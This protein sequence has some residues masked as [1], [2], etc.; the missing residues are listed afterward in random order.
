MTLR[1]AALLFF[2]AAAL[3]GERLPTSGDGH[4]MNAGEGAVP[5]PMSAPAAAAAALS[6]THAA[7]AAAGAPLAP[8]AAAL[9]PTA[10]PAA[11]KAAAPAPSF[12]VALPS[13][14]E[15]LKG[16]FVF[17]TKAAE[18][19]KP[20]LRLAWEASEAGTYVV[21]GYRVLRRLQGAGFEVRLGA[22]SPLPDNAAEDSVEIGKVY[23][24]AVVAVDAKGNS[25][26][27]S[28]TFSSDLLHLDAGLLAPRS[29]RSLTATS[30]RNS[31]KLSWAA[32]DPWLS[33]ISGYKVFRHG[34]DAPLTLTAATSYEDLSPPALTDFTYHVL[35]VDSLGRESAPSLT[36]SARATGT[37][38]PSAPVNLTATVKPEKASLAWEKSD[39]G[40]AP[41][42]AYLLKRVIEPGPGELKEETKLFAPLDLSRTSYSDTVD[43]DHFY[44]YELLAADLE[45]N[46]S[47]PSSLR[48]WVPGKPFN[49]T[50]LLLMPTAYT[51]LPDR[52]T[53]GNV[54]VLFDL[55]IGELYETYTNPKTNITKTGLFQPLQ[56]SGQLGV[57]SLDLKESFL[58]ETFLTP[59]MAVGF[60]GAALVPFGGLSSQQVAVTSQG[61]GFQ[62]LGNVYAVVSKRLA[63]RTAVHFGGMYGKLSDS[64]VSVAPQ[65]W[66]LTLRHLTPGGNYPDLFNRFLDPKLGAS[67]QGAPHMLFGGL[68]FPLSVP[69]GFATW[70]TGLKAELMAPIYPEMPEY[71]SQEERGQAWQ[72]L[73]LIWNFHIDNLPLFGF[74][75][76]LFQFKGGIEWIAFYHIPDL[77]WSF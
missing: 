64:L 15:A 42:T 10:V 59:A 4:P 16:E 29:P 30:A 62:T 12:P 8:Q 41:V 63:N 65:D 44:R 5:R 52:D 56:S 74:E 75:F 25:S 55:Y 76:S 26:A 71:Y 3:H 20:M 73:P 18:A 13:A 17:L 53:G 49:K 6:V 72:M 57:V 48:L 69:F 2:A 43:G 32:P 14:P 38:A 24:Y 31:A 36:V 23:D 77:T 35:S 22:D 11:P 1:A 9:S 39:P 70:K 28:G 45:G 50:A 54:N 47:P 58:P 68:Q 37:L 40:T 67:I 61:T 34:K 19:V 7:S 33:P 21:R 51:N 66:A 46:K 27:L 60:Y